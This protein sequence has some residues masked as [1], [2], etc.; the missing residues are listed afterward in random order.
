MDNLLQK[1][2][3]NESELRSFIIRISADELSKLSEP[4]HYPKIKGY[5]HQ[6]LDLTGLTTGDI[7]DFFSEFYK[8][9]KQ[10]VLS[11]HR[12]P[13]TN[14]VI[15]I[16]YHFLKERDMQ[17]YLSS[18]LWHMLK[19]YSRLMHI[20]IPYCNTQVFMYTLEHLSKAHLF[21]REK[22]IA[23]AVYHITRMMQNRYSDAILSKNA[24]E[25][26]GFITASRTR[27]QQ[28]ISSFQNAYFRHHKEGSRYRTPYT[29]E[30]GEEYE[31]QTLEKRTQ[32]VDTIKKSITVYKEI[33]EKALLEA[34]TLTKVRESLARLIVTELSNITY[35]EEIRM[36]LDLFIRD[37]KSTP[38]LCGK[39]FFTYLRSLMAIKRTTKP[40]YFKQQ[41]NELLVKLLKA[42][43][44]FD[45]YNRL[46]SQSQSLINSF[47]ALY[48]TMFARNKLC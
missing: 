25:I 14:L 37:I 15:F 12:D 4:C 38:A 45:N 1:A 11:I 19:E 18:L 34:K 48:I 20:R 29:G 41:I 9:S 26:A 27:I 17:S 13:H 5:F 47:L 23:G 22:G 6:L 10:A 28:S 39:E 33:D 35:Q 40:V 30:G 42:T 3:I 7:K 21:V 46:T 44:T 2:N 24:D 43:N 32:V 16:A 36:I 31:Y 8:G